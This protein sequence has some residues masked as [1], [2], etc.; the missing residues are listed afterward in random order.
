MLNEL[1]NKILI[2][3]SSLLKI[4]RSNLID[5]KIKYDEI[6]KKSI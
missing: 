6:E 5:K 1:K 4:L 2:F 3:F